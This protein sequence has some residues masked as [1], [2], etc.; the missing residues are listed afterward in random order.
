MFEQFELLLL[1]FQVAIVVMQKRSP[2]HLSAAS[3]FGRVEPALARL[4]CE[5]HLTRALT[6]F[7]FRQVPPPNATPPPVGTRFML[8]CQSFA[9][10]PR[11]KDQDP[12]TTMNTPPA[13]KGN[14]IEL[15]SSDEFKEKSMVL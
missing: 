15:S 8:A 13:I 11:I 3:L 7:G 9:L 10:R 14:L 2:C 4:S 6:S 1:T 5:P 12:N